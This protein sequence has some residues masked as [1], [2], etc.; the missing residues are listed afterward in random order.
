MQME[1]FFIVKII[2]R[3]FF[4]DVIFGN[5]LGYFSS[6]NDNMTQIVFK[7]KREFTSKAQDFKSTNSI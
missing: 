6:P 7:N 1:I 3:L 4:N 5:I 2:F